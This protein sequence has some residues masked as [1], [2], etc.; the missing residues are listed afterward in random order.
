LDKD[1]IIR[2][3]Q[4]QIQHQT[5]MIAEQGVVIKLMEARIELL[6][7]SQK[8][9]SSNSSKPPSSD[10]GKPQRTHSL[11]TKSGKKPGGQRGHSGETLCFTATP[12]AVVVHT[13]GQCNCC[14]KSL[15][16]SA[17]ADYERRQVF[18]IPSIEM[19]VTE[20]RSEIKSCPFCHT[21][22]RGV[23]PEAVSR[24]V[25]YG[26][27]VQQLAVY[28]TQYQ[29]L[30]YGRTAEIFKDL[31]GHALS[32]SFL[33]NNNHRC[34]SN[35]QPFIKDLKTVLLSQPVLHADETGFHFEGRRNWLHTIST[36][37]HSFYAPHIRRGTAAMHD[38]SVLPEYKG[39]LVHDFWKSYNEFECSHALCNVHHLRDLTFCHEIEKSSWAGHAKQMLLNLHAKVM[40]AKD[41]GATSLSRGQLHYWRKKYD[42][43]MNEGLSMHPVPKKQKG[44][45]GVTKKSKTQNLIERFV[46]YKEQI[47]AF[48][49]NFLI[50]FGNN[51][52]EQAIRMMKVKQK[53][54][55]CF[56]SEQGAK[57]FADIRSYISTMKK[58][59]QPIMQALAA[60]IQGVPLNLAS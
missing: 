8:K 24:P 44:K 30:P 14:G 26:I 56:R 55:G 13:A 17:V 7:N 12:N 59:G 42:D 4:E 57:D 49:K 50:P 3:Q 29:L 20:H 52:A 31:F 15:S 38:M 47:L 37:K 36:D 48:A 46:D 27:N 25:Q 6:E 16:G 2:L 18:D 58:Q 5:K 22:S 54:S 41:A 32:S 39:V 10:T 9:D 45:R 33:V 21:L 35:L 28:F 23:F 1:L 19:Q 43:L 60:A 34:A 40:I 51:I 53:I 11:R